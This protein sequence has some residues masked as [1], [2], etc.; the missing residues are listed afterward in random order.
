MDTNGH[1]ILIDDSQRD[2]AQIAESVQHFLPEIHKRT[3]LWILLDFK[4]KS[5]SP[6]KPPS[7]NLTTYRIQRMGI[8]IHSLWKLFEAYVGI[9]YTFGSCQEY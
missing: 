9:L 1:L 2:L 6:P 4:R 5:S 7:E 8:E 3:F